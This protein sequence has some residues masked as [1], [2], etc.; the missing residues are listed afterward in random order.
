[1]LDIYDHCY[2]YPFQ[3]GQFKL[4]YHYQRLLNQLSV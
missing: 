4:Q 1:M 2:Y 3:D